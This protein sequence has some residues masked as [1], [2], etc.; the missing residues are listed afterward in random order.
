MKSNFLSG[1]AALLVSLPLLSGTAALAETTEMD[2]GLVLTQ[3]SL[4]ERLVQDNAQARFSRVQA[5]IAQAQIDFASGVYQPSFFSTMRYTDQQVAN[6]AEDEATGR[7]QGNTTTFDER[8]AEL[9]FGV[10][11]PLKTG[12]ELSLSFTGLERDNTFTEELTPG[13]SEYVGGVDA[14]LSQPLWRNF[15]ARESK[16]AIEQ[17]EVG[18]ERSLLEN[19]QTLLEVAFQGLRQYWLVYRRAQFRDIDA[20]ALRTAQDTV[21]IAEQLV[22]AGIQPPLAAME[23]EARVIEREA[24][25]RRSVTDLKEAQAD[26]ATLLNV[27][28]GEG[29]RIEGM[30]QP[31]SRLIERPDS[32]TLYATRVLAQWPEFRVTRLTRTIES[33]QLDLARETGKPAVDFIVGYSTSALDRDRNDAWDDSFSSQNPSWYAGVEL[34]VKLGADKQAQAQANAASMRMMQ[35]DIDADSIRVNVLNRLRTRLEQAESAHEQ[36]QLMSRREALQQAIYKEQERQFEAGRIPA[37][38]LHDSMD[39]LVEIQRRAVDARVTYQL[40]LIAL[41]LVEGSLFDEYGLS[42]LVDDD[43]LPANSPR[44][45]FV[46]ADRL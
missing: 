22:D 19:R 16:M 3:K 40:S 10:S 26:L 24:E 12:G 38:A 27:E 28:Q 13:A 9:D 30:D 32:L 21:T 11:A 42:E 25:L 35:A 37:N 43:V 1:A 23:V 2:S 31:E 6:S 5:D 20:V 7:S 46:E 44:L 36:M 8:R 17:A 33:L 29:V 34:N 45:E 18:H 15:M 14:R 41:R 39:D 4:L